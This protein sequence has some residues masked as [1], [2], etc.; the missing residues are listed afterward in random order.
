VQRLLTEIGVCIL[1]SIPG[2]KGLNRKRRLI[3]ENEKDRLEFSGRSYSYSHRLSL[4]T[5]R[6]TVYAWEWAGCKLAEIF[7]DLGLHQ[8][9]VFTASLIA[10]LSTSERWVPSRHRDLFFDEIIKFAEWVEGL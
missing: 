6:V 2:L 1:E 10:G 3:Y 5:C 9:I 4:T 8:E 7:S